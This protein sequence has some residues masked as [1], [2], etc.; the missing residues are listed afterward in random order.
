MQTVSAKV[1][2]LSQPSVFNA[3]PSLQRQ[4]AKNGLLD[5]GKDELQQGMSV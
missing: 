4:L 5:G 1:A 2:H 3:Y